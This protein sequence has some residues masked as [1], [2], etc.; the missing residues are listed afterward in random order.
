MMKKSVIQNIDQIISSID[1]VIYA[2][3]AIETLLPIVKSH[4]CVGSG[5]QSAPD[6]LLIMHP[7]TLKSFRHYLSKDE[8]YL[9][10]EET[11]L[12][13]K[14]EFVVSTQVTKLQAF[15]VPIDRF[16]LM[17]R[18]RKPS[19]YGYKMSIA[20]S[21]E[22]LTQIESIEMSEEYTECGEIE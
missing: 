18:G 14:I 9:S 3:I 5:I 19:V 15:L 7:E 11:Q 22:W 4:Y 21:E 17:T 13:K 2:V 6:F 16:K 1:E 20:I 8:D 10:K 12:L